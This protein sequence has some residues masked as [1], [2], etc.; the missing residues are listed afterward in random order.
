MSILHHSP[1]DYFSKDMEKI[2]HIKEICDHLNKC[3]PEDRKIFRDSIITTI[4]LETTDNPER[5]LKEL[6]DLMKEITKTYLAK[7]QDNS[8]YI[9][10]KV[11]QKYG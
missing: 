5:V 1:T 8:I 11:G 7:N 9:D 2:Y 3:H 10:K 4:M 6:F